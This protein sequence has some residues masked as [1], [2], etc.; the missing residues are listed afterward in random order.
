MLDHGRPCPTT[1]LYR[2]YG[3]QVGRWA[4][5]LSRS[6][7]D[8][9]DIVQEVFLT[10]H[11]QRAT[12]SRLHSPPAWLLQI[13]RNVVRHAWRSR[14]RASRRE[15]ACDLD[16]LVSPGRDPLQE[17]ERRRTAR[18]L[19]AAIAGLGDDYRHIYWLCEVDGLSAAAVAEMT[20]I[21]PQTL[22]VRRFRARRLLARRLARALD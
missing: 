15:E 9:D 11:R 16:K 7:G 13:T 8:A 17:L 22:R 4:A 14:A 6:P 5:R 20:G 12:A 19:D 18:A 3:H 1:Q 10:V 21:N 2:D